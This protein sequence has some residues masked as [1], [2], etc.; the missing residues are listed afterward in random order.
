MRSKYVFVVGGGKWYYEPFSR[1][2]IYT[3]DHNILDYPEKI[4]LVLFTGGEDIGPDLYGHEPSV[5]TYC[6]PKRDRYEVSIYNEV[7]ELKLPMAGVCRGAQLL[8]AMAGGTLY[9]HVNNH[10]RSHDVMTWDGRDIWMSSSHHQMQIPPLGAEILAWAAP[11]LSDIYIGEN[12]EEMPAPAFEC[13]CVHYPSI[14]AVGMQYHP[15]A[16]TESSKG[17]KYAGELVDAFLR[18]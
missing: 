7:L 15:E 11:K 2:G 4:E 14:R 1:F 16:M 17:F 5:L 6:S 10:G 12:D 3:D 18:K 13:E 8:C 9:Q